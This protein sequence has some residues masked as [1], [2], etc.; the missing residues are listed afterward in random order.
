MLKEFGIKA[1]QNGDRVSLTFQGVTKTIGN[2]A[3]EIQA[4][5]QGI[6]DINFGGA[7]EAR[8]A[9]LDGAISNLGDTWDG[10]LRKIAQNGAGEI[11]T[12]TVIAL[13]NALNDLGAIIDTVSGS[14]SKEAGAVKEATVI[15]QA[16][17]TAFE[18]IAVVGVNVAYILEQIGRDMGAFA[19]SFV[20]FTKGEFKM[21]A[22]IIEMRHKE[23]QEARKAVDAK[24]AAIL[25]A[26]KQNQE[27]QAAEAAAL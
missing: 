9:T 17:T 16:L 2:N 12:R 22:D 20:M 3:K 19:A 1:K 7:M 14:V 13:G 4:Y 10:F 11:A 5:L 24:S 26:S 18:A 25:G 6:G 15:H 8:A 27:A 23:A 21:S